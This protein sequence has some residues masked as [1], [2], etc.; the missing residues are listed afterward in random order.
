MDV[1]K[2]NR[3]CYL[4]EDVEYLSKTAKK[5]LNTQITIAK[6]KLDISRT[7]VKRLY[8]AQKSTF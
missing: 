8:I 7:L 4:V 1:N 2:T 3:K 5:S 6:V